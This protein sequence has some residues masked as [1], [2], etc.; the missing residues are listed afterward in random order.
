MLAPSERETNTG[1]RCLRRRAGT[2]PVAVSGRAPP[3]TV[4]MPSSA[5]AP[6]AVPCHRAPPRPRA[7]RRSYGTG[8]APAG[9]LLAPGRTALDRLEQLFHETERG[10]S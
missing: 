2:A 9:R 5:A 6:Y 3:G 10:S 7:A 8:A 4:P 1:A